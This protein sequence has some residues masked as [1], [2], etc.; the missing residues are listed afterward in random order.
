MH[1]K[2]TEEYFKKNNVLAEDA[3]KELLEAYAKTSSETWQ[4][5]LGIS[6]APQPANGANAWIKGNW[7][8][9]LPS[10]PGTGDDLAQLASRVQAG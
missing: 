4:K 1:K 9:I 5:L 3:S 10:L 2:F 8:R 7:N 6:G